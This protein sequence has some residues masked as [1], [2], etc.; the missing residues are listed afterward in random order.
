MAPARLMRAAMAARVISG[1][2]SPEERNETTAMR[3][4]GEGAGLEQDR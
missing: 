1:R 3:E 4:D 2:S